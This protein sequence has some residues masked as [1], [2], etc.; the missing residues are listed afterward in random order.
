MDN[1]VPFTK[2]DVRNYLDHAITR[3]RKRVKDDGNSEEDTLVAMC[4]VDAFQ[5]V[6]VS[7]FGELLPK[8]K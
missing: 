5:S 8:D 4:Y 1:I 6:R 3:W 2:E 7:L